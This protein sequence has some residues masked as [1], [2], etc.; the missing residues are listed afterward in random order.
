MIPPLASGP[1]QSIERDRDPLSGP[2][3]DV[4]N[5]LAELYEQSYK[6]SSLNAY[7]SAISSTHEKVDGHPV[8]KHPVIVRILKRAF[9]KRPPL[10]KYTTIW[11]VSKI[12]SY[13]CTLGDNDSLSLKS[14]SL[15]LVVLL[16]LHQGPM[17]CLI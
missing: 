9:N 4:A 7:R 2:I 8:G 3:R 5:F 6:Y 13:I 12:T 17:I 15:K 10:P 1:T 11:E 14:L 16:A